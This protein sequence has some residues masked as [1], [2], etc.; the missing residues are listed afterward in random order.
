MKKD[1]TELSM[2]SSANSLKPFTLFY[3]G[4]CPLCLAEI[5]FLKSRNQSGLL[6]SVDINSANYDPQK[7]RVSCEE[8]L[9]IVSANEFF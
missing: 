9:A 2:T 5:T 3:D 1:Y 6:I 4:A 7:I 8:I